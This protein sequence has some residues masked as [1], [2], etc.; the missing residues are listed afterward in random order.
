[1]RELAVGEEARQ[2]NDESHADVPTGQFGWAVKVALEALLEQAHH[3]HDSQLH[4]GTAEDGIS[5]GGGL[6]PL[7]GAVDAGE[8]VFIKEPEAPQRTGSLSPALS[9]RF[10]NSYAQVRLT[11][12]PER[13]RAVDCPRCGKGTLSGQAS[14]GPDLLS[15][16]LG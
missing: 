7:V 6:L 3:N 13:A 5:L 10:R 8:Q 14:N 12:P 16:V 4:V 11:T 1:M 2:A 15:L 9:Q